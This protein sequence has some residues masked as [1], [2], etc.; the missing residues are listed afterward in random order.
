MPPI[1]QEWRKIKES[2]QAYM[3]SK[4]YDKAITQ[5]TK[6]LGIEPSNDEANF[7]LRDAYFKSKKELPSWLNEEG[8]FTRKTEGNFYKELASELEQPK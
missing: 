2:Y 4:N 7:Y 8:G 5:A 3:V 1:V 6:L